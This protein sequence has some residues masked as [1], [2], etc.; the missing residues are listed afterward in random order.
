MNLLQDHFL[1]ESTEEAFVVGE[2]IYD[3][4]QKW[5]ERDD[6]YIWDYKFDAIGQEKAALEKTFRKSQDSGIQNDLN[7]FILF[8]KNVVNRHP[9]K[10][11]LPQPPAL[12][13]FFKLH[14]TL[15][16]RGL[17]CEV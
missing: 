7:D 10:N 4:L 1:E 12:E 11:S 5:I 14:N 13:L 15:T 16:D 17:F 9:V 8:V 2:P 6:A 3:G